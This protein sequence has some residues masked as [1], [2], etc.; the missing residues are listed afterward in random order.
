VLEWILSTGAGLVGFSSYL[1]NI[2]RNLWLARALKERRPAVRV[3]FGGPEIVEGQPALGSP[4]VD[5]YVTGEGEEAFAR[6]L[7][8]W[9]RTGR[10]FRVYRGGTLGRLAAVP[11]PNLAGTVEREAGDPLYV[12]TMRGC[13]HSCT[14]CSYARSFPGIRR[15]PA[16]RLEGIFPWAAA[17]GVP[18]IYLMDP[19][20]NSTP[21]WEET[22]ARIARLNSAGIPLHT[23]IRL[24][25]VN[26][27]RAEL[28][29]AAGFR[30]VEVGLQSTNHAALRAVRR[31]WR[32][33]EFLEGAR[34]LLQR[35]IR[36]KTGV[37]IGL[38]EDTPDGFLSTVEFLREC[39]LAAD[40]EIYPL[41]VLPGTRLR[42]EA[43]ERRVRYMSSPPYWALGTGSM[44]ESGMIECIRR[45]ERVLDVEFF[46]PIPPRFE[47]PGHGLIGFQD[48]RPSGA[49]E[50]LLF[51][52]E[53]LAS[54]LT[55]LLSGEQL[56]ELARWEE[57]GRRLLAVTPHS[58]LKLVVASEDPLSPQDV[59]RLAE[60]FY[61]PAHYFNQ[62]HYFSEDP[63]GRFSV[64]LFR[65]AGR[66]QTAERSAVSGEPLDLI[67]RYSPELLARGRHVLDQNPFLLM[68]GGLGAAEEREI[69]RIYRG[70][71]ELLLRCPSFP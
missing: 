14:Y 64:R 28:F 54:D 68:A 41:C 4:S 55:L 67:M 65:L 23:E 35:G 27:E 38:P 2:Q 11:E 29:A 24:E 62:V 63:Q 25:S 17:H 42:A 61:H 69:A 59:D 13:P 21:R 1:W 44:D 56:H 45:A 49:A 19:S 50:R 70:H 7:R 60:A 12:E 51:A 34:L 9:T 31:S 58:L 37:I 39:G 57:L 48:L 20:F 30:S 53:R 8:E 32:R 22:L 10:L 66:I 71:E 3:M 16:E 6:A 15:F 26:G 18:E 52:P 33:R 46:P 47:D 40:M 36:V 43:A 5:S